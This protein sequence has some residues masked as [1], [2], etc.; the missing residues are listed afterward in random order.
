[1]LFRSPQ[2]VLPYPGSGELVEVTNGVPGWNISPTASL[3]LMGHNDL[4]L[5]GAG[6]AIL[7]PDWPSSQI[8]EGTYTVELFASIMGPPTVGFIF[9]TGQIPAGSHSILFYGAGDIGMSFAGQNV[10]LTSVG[11]GPNYTI[12]G[13]DISMF[14]GQTGQL[15]F[16]GNGLLDNIV[17]SPTAIPE[18]STLGMFATG[19]VF[20]AWRSGRRFRAKDKPLCPMD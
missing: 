6:V 17:F 9:Q 11:S 12:F 13:G 16:E 1:M 19:A 14:A 5:S 2:Q 4:P 7:G 3:N 15:V 8:L 18:P 20:L 10:P